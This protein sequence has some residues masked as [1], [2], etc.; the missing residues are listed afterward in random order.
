MAVH[1]LPMK[2]DARI[3]IRLTTEQKAAMERA[4]LACDMP[5]AVWLRGI[6]MSEALKIGVRAIKRRERKDES[7]RN[8]ASDQ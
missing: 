5:V 1:Y 8:H 2:N 7:G 4:A 3:N 6:A